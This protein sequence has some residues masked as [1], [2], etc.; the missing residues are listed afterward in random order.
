MGPAGPAGFVC[1]HIPPP[2]TLRSGPAE[3]EATVLAFDFE[4]TN[5]GATPIGTVRSGS[6]G[7]GLLFSAFTAGTGVELFTS[8]GTL[9]GTGLVKNFDGTTGSTFPEIFRVV[10]LVAL[11]SAETPALGREPYAVVKVGGTYQSQLLGDLNPGAAD[12]RPRDFV[13]ANST[14]FFVAEN[15]A[16]GR[17]LWKTG[18]T[19]ATTVLVKDIFPGPGSSEPEDLVAFGNRL[20]FRACSPE[21]GCELWTSDG[22]TVGTTL[23]KD[24]LPGTRSG[25]PAFLTVVDGNLWFRACDDAAGCEVWVSDGTAART[26]RVADLHPGPL[27]SNPGSSSLFGE[28]QFVPS[29]G[30]IFFPAD[31]GSGEELWAVSLF[32]FEDGFESGN[33]TAWSATVP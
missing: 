33:S 21:A 13:V 22:T 4:P 1:E 32:L 16:N 17:E 15:A 9:A 23:F 20:F 19:P 25:V 8:D 28:N 11:V 24:L 6:F 14:T 30:R 5:N 7:N 27:S 10:G 29:N 31:D 18:G 26:R 2:V 12:S 3:M